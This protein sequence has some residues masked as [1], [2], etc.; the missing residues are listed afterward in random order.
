[1]VGLVLRLPPKSD[2]ESCEYRFEC[3]TNNYPFCGKDDI[4]VGDDN[5]PRLNGI[6]SGEWFSYGFRFTGTN[7]RRC[8]TEQELLFASKVAE[9]KYKSV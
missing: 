9:D 7:W 1:M 6:P 5:I 2:C 3:Y 4:T 8:M